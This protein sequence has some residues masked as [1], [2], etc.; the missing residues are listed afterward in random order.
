MAEH[1]H[2][3]SHD[4]IKVP[5]TEAEWDARY[6][7][8]AERMWSGNPN[9]VLVAETAA[10]TPGTALDV[11]CGEGA[12]ALWL[13]ARGMEGHRNRHLLGS[14]GKGCKARGIA[15]ATG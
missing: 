14:P 13:A 11:G 5:F 8:S 10:L 1:E 9:P 7:T 4:D 12:D 15:R 2:H 6:S 3:A